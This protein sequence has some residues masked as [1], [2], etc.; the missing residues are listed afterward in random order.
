MIDSAAA[1]LEGC[2]PGITLNRGVQDGIG[3]DTVSFVIAEN[4]HQPRAGSRYLARLLKVSEG[5][6]LILQD[7]PTENATVL[8]ALQ[9]RLGGVEVVD[10]VH[11]LVAVELEEQFH[12]SCW[13]QT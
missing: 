6:E 2:G 1:S 7:R 3:K 11:L 4:L 10:R 8:M 13:F 5:E 9:L 12:E